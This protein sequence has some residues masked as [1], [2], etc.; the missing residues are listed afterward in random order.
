MASHGER[1]N[2]LRPYYIPPSIGDDLYGPGTSAATNGTPRSLPHGNGT[3]PYSHKAR[4]IFA[5]LDYKDYI[6]EPSPSVV[7]SAKDVVDELLW[8]YTSVLMAQPFEV[9]KTIL[10]VRSQA[11]PDLSAPESALPTPVV[12]IEP[13]LGRRQRS[14]YGGF[15]NANDDPVGLARACFTILYPA[16]SI[17]TF[18]SSVTTLPTT[19]PTPTSPATS[20]P[21]PPIRHLLSTHCRTKDAVQS[22][23]MQHRLAGRQGH[24]AALFPMG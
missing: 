1:V 5:D 6:A 9:A 8:R 14:S 23:H 17:L 19:T 20:L 4:D 10:Q 21:T 15:G 3:S 11:P 18:P 22:L 24:Q 16:C 7:Q 2:P 12:N 13:E